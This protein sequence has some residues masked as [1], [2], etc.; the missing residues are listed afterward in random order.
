VIRTQ[1]QILADLAAML[2]NPVAKREQLV[3][4]LAA[5]PAYTESTTRQFLAAQDVTQTE[6]NAVVSEV[7]KLRS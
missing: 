3:S 7:A 5:N 4:E 2:A 6:I 1:I